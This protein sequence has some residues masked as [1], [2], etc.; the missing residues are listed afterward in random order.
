LDVTGGE[1]EGCEECEESWFE[2]IHCCSLKKKKKKKKLRM[3]IE[4]EDESVLT[5]E[6]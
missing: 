3:E 6:S 1:N 4:E 5:R 2:G